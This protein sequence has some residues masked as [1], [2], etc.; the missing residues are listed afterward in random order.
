M[1]VSETT[2]PRGARP[3]D[4]YQE[5]QAVRARILRIEDAEMKIGLSGVGAEEAREGEP[6]AAAPDAAPVEP[7]AE[8]AAAAPA[9]APAKKK[10]TRK[11]AEPG[12]PSK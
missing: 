1:H 7:P 5:G 9:E 2:M 4:H 3:Q 10:R 6:A 8:P 12:A 11:K